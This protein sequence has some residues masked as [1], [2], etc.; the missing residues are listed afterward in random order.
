MN[1]FK[2]TTTVAMAAGLAMLACGPAAAQVSA[3]A[4]GVPAQTQTQTQTQ[5]Q[6]SAAPGVARGGLHRSEGLMMLDYQSIAVPN[7]PSLDLLGFHVMNRVADGLYLGVGAYAPMFQGEYGG[8]MAFDVGAHVQRRLWGRVFGDAGLSIGGG[9]GG[10]ST[11]Q[12][13]ELSGTGGFAKRYAGVG[14]AFDGF[15]LGANLSRM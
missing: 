5:G 6:T 7:N 11:A 8:F 2:Q 13:I 12:S 1:R 3:P 4:A 15:S 10:K 14:M 9:G